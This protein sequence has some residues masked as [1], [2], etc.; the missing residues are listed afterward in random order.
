MLL[1]SATPGNVRGSVKGKFMRNAS[2]LHSQITD[3]PHLWN[4]NFDASI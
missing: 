1:F 3:R 4:V 2:T